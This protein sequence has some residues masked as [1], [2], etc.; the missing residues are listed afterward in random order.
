VEDHLEVLQERRQEHVAACLDHTLRAADDLNKGD[1][2]FR[3]ESASA[4][5][6]ARDEN[7][8]SRCIC[9]LRKFLHDFELR[10][11]VQSPDLSIR[12]HGRQLLGGQISLRLQQFGQTAG[13]AV[14]M[15]IGR[16]AALWLL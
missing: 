11:A 15:Q 1:A 3:S 6:R 7:R 14:A 2:M 13:E 16:G 4:Q 8:L 5:A 10:T 12:K 9:V